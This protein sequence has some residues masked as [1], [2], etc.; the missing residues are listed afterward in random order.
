MKKHRFTFQFRADEGEYL[1]VMRVATLLGLSRVTIYKKIATKELSGEQI[2]GRF[3]V[4]RLS[5]DS[6]METL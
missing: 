5:V 4:Y 6:Y 3:L 1:G 2:A